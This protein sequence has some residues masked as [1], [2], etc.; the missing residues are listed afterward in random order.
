MIINKGFQPKR[1]TDSRLPPGQSEVRGFPVLA[2]GPT[3]HVPRNDWSLEVTGLVA[4]PQKWDWDDFQKLPMTD[5]EVDI[6]C[7]T[8][9]SK[10]DTKWR[11]VTLDE[12]IKIV[13]PKAGAEYIVMSSSDGYTTN[14]PVAD[15]INGQGMVATAYDGQ[16]ITDEHGGP[17]RLLVPHLYFWKSA[18]WLKKIEFVDKDHPGFWETRGYHNYGDPWKEERYSF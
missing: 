17:A 5:T 2:F 13:Q 9:W 7:V 4:Q 14:L 18:K 1:E 8:R 16:D 3:A 11:G 15:V 6:H 10:F 12:I